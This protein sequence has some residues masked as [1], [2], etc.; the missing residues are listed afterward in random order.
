MV[1]LTREWALVSL[2]AAV[3]FEVAGTLFLPNILPSMSQP[4][5]MKLV[6]YIFAV[7]TCYLVS[8]T[9]LLL[10][11]TAINISTTYATWAGSGVCLVA[12]FGH[13]IYKDTIAWTNGIGILIVVCGIVMVHI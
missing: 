5:K 6:A 8:F 12:V 13:V 1:E 11:L 3:V 2:L 10:T 4:N 7:G 9:M